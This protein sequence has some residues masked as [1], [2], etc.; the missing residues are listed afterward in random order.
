MAPETLSPMLVFLLGAALVLGAACVRPKRDGLA[1]GRAVV[2]VLR[3][4]AP[5]SLLKM[6]GLVVVVVTVLRG[7][8]RLLPKAMLEDMNCIDLV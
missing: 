1:A 4:R 7:A 3:V 8:A 6:P 2:V 5:V